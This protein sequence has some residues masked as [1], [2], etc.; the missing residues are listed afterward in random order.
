MVWTGLIK[1]VA[2]PFGGVFRRFIPVPVPASMTVFGAAMYS[3][4]ALVF[5]SAGVSKAPA[6]TGVAKFLQVVWS[7]PGIFRNFLKHN[8]TKN[9]R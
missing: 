1:L 7:Q 5:Y 2:A 3:Y 9:C 6:S 4:L 8:R